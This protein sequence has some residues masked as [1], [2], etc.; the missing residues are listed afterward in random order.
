[1]LLL[2]GI[3]HIEDLD[4][5][6]FID[7][8]SKI[9]DMHAS[10]KLDGSQLWVGIDEKGKLFTSRAGKRKAAEN[11]YSADSYPMIAN[12]NGFRATHL[13]LEKEQEKIKNVL[14][15]GQTVELEVLYGRQPNAVTYGAN[16]KNYIAFLRGVDGTPDEKA[17]ALATALKGVTTTVS[18]KVIDTTD[19]ENLSE[20]PVSLQFQFVAAQK[21]DTK[22]V[23][24]TNIKSKLAKLRTFLEKGSTAVGNDEYLNG[25]LLKTPLNSFPKETRAEAKIAKQQLKDKVQTQFKLP[26]KKELLDKFVSQ[27]KSPLA[28]MDLHPNEDIGIEG[29][30][31]RDSLGNQIKIVDKDKFTTINKFNHS[32]RAAI[33]GTIRTTDQS[34]PIED[35]GGILGEMKIRIAD[36]LG[37][38]DLARGAEAKKI[39]ASL[40]GQTTAATVKAAEKQFQGT[41]DFQGIKRK[42]LADIENTQRVLKQNLDS[43]K[44][45]KDKE[46]IRLKSGKILG[47]SD[48]NIKKTLLTFAE[49]KKD[50]DVLHSKVSKSTRLGQIIASLYG[51]HIVAVQNADKEITEQLLTE[52]HAQASLTQFESKDSF[53]LINGYLATLLASMVFFKAN[54]SDGIRILRDHKNQRMARWDPY[55]SNLNLW[56]YIIWRATTKPVK[57]VIGALASRRINRWTHLIAKPR[58]LNLHMRFSFGKEKLEKIDWEDCRK[59][60]KI[61]QREEGINT[62]RINMIIDGVMN[63]DTDEFDKKIKTLNALYYYLYQFVQI[64]PLLLRIS[65]LQ[66]DLMLS[67]SPA[68][69]QMINENKK[70]SLLQDIIGICETADD[71]ATASGTSTTAA[72]IA[73][74]ETRI[75]HGTRPIERRKRNH[76]INKNKF[77]NPNKHHNNGPK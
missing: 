53:T 58:W 12:Y 63:Y 29:V 66:K 2:E 62:H 30:V 70:M 17:D 64:S 9:A 18:T 13:A 49:A 73:P 42:I 3:S 56:G 39:F 43:F 37:N 22:K 27:V 32:I 23:E 54:F 44:K 45:T 72:A 6:A 55:M 76:S 75:F 28:A 40:K 51:R 11:M 31:L 69:D 21:I 16:D 8:V 15:P 59:I 41:T 38:K 61:L 46:K 52:T 68:T 34:R 10:E 50:L 5:D 65:K 67:Q 24:D 19:G 35:R 33:S 60:I 71:S 77:A 14:Q 20:V 1:M 7:A 47:L 25:E 74:V 48:A 57:K 4:V 36:L 26:I